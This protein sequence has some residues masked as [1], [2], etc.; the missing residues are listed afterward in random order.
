MIA[1]ITWGQEEDTVLRVGEVVFGGVGEDRARG[2]ERDERDPLHNSGCV[3]DPLLGLRRHLLCLPLELAQ[4]AVADSGVEVIGFV[5]SS[6][7]FPS[8]LIPI[9]SSTIP[10]VIMIAP[11]IT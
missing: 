4:P 10:P 2:R 7:D 3:D 8:A 11:P 1:V 9:A 6:S 5:M